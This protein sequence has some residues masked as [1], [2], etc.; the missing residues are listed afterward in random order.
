[1]SNNTWSTSI[2]LITD[3]LDLVS[4]TTLNPIITALASRDQFLFDQQ[5]LNTSKNILMAFDIPA[6]DTVSASSVVYL[7]ATTPAT[8]KLAK[9][10]FTPDTSP[11]TL[12]PALSSY[13]FGIVA[14]VTSG[15]AN[16][17][18]RGLIGGI[19]LDTLKASASETATTGPMYLSYDV[20]G[21]L[22]FNHSGASVYVGSYL[23]TVNGVN[24][25]F[26]L[27]PNIDS[28]D[29]LYYNYRGY[30]Y[31]DAI[32]GTAEKNGDDKYTITSQ[33][34][35]M[36]K[37]GWVSATKA[38]STYLYPIPTVTNGSTYTAVFYYNIPSAAIIAASTTLT[39]LQKQDATILKQAFPAFP[40]SF[41]MLY[42]NG[43]LQLPIDTDHV[44]GSYLVN[45][46]GL[47]WF[48]ALTPPWTLDINDP[49]TTANILLQ[50]TKLN[51]FY[52][53]SVVTTITPD[54]TDHSNN[55]LSLIDKSSLTTAKSG[56]LLLKFD[57][58]VST[59]E[60]A[61]TNNDLAIKSIEY[62][63]ETGSLIPTTGP[64]VAELIA[65]PG[66]SLTAGEPGSGSIT[67][68]LSDYVLSGDVEDIE[69]EEADFVY[70]GLHSY[71]RLRNP[72]V[73]NQRIGFVG[74]FLLPYSLPTATPCLIKLL[75]FNEANNGAGGAPTSFNFEYLVSKEG[76]DPSTNNAATRVQYTPGTYE[77]IVTDI[78]AET[79]LVGA[80]PA[81][82]QIPSS[83]LT[84][85]SYVNFRITRI[86]TPNQVNN[87]NVIGVRWSIGDTITGLPGYTKQFKQIYGAIDG[88]LT[89][90][91]PTLIP[92]TTTAIYIADNGT[93]F[94]YFGGVWH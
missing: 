67:V 79:V 52:K 20:P 17:Y 69:P 81:Y 83:A 68:S 21:K 12:S 43:V 35:D 76:I 33:D 18:I 41:T 22:T 7:D 13:V 24:N 92:A 1:M 72:T 66:V 10:G 64:V 6:D 9:A 42:R 19:S 73:T 27:A 8:L 47:W 50:T 80:D 62:S 45:Q 56:D 86:N 90:G 31:T 25:C 23:G 53:S 87:F 59:P 91:K 48:D 11:A 5:G 15:I 26:F 38:N 44:N 60:T 82:F 30:I 89:N 34:A 36:L 58:P 54:T 28:I 84:A 37:V 61:I 88:G 49:L 78:A 94:Q 39:A 70:K 71:L 46:D 55:V 74:K 51:P 63:K 14:T 16:V 75:A 2:P 29:Q 77:I 85:N 57:L 4:G 40:S 93:Q 32:A 3:G 65:G